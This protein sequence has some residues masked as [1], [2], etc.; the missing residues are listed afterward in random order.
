MSTDLTDN[1]LRELRIFLNHYWE[2]V[3]FR[4]EAQLLGVPVTRKIVSCSGSSPTTG[5]V[6]A[7]FPFYS[8]VQLQAPIPLSAFCH[9][10]TPM[11]MLLLVYLQEICDEQEEKKQKIKKALARR[12]WR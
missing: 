3:Q 5:F 8:H 12:R 4:E 2:A 10:Y 6:P 11:Y 9:S 7:R 1:Q